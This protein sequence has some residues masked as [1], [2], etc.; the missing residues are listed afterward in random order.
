MAR[1]HLI[2][3]HVLWRELCHFASLSPHVFTFN[4]V[5][6]GLH[7]TPELLK[8][9]LQ[10][11][12]DEAPE[13]CDAVLLGYGLCSNGAAGVV[14]RTK[15]LVIPRAHDCIT[16]FL[17]SKERYREYFDAHPG[18]YWYTP[19]WIE[20]SLQPGLDRYNFLRRDYV[21]KYGEDNADYLMEMEQGWM[22]EYS[23]AAYIDLGFSDTLRF[24]EYT[25]ECAQWLGW[26]CDELQGESGLIQSFVTGQWDSERFLIVEPGQT[27]VASHDET[28]VK[29]G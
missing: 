11:A 5:K 17:G 10:K 20:C 15:P 2:A 21:E 23:N 29:A 16:L 22:K 13:E 19:G 12:V 26:K 3:C 24:R 8:V 14:A 27:I 7:N 1:Y 18:T 6:Q 9:Q 4:F 25:R 28:V